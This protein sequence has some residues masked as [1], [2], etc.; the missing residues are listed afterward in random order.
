MQDCPTGSECWNLDDGYECIA[1]ATFD[2]YNTTLVY[3]LTMID[4]T[5]EEEEPLIADSM[6]IEYR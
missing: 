5:E 2:G 1:N 4:S 3:N 6:I